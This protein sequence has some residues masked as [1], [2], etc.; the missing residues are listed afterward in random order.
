[1]LF[2]P[3]TLSWLQKQDDVSIHPSLLCVASLLMILLILTVVIHC[4]ILDSHTRQQL[5]WN[6]PRNLESNY[7][8]GSSVQEKD[9]M[10]GRVSI[11]WLPLIHGSDPCLLHNQDADEKKYYLLKKTGQ[12][13]VEIAWLARKI[14]NVNNNKVIHRTSGTV[15]KRNLQSFE[16]YFAE[17]YYFLKV[18]S[19]TFDL[20]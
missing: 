20:K 2:V 14:K 13:E 7:N 17:T 1:M 5:K 3:C 8:H 16:D 4:C 12:T 19:G 18:N 9:V 6:L 11:L 15:Q 10:T